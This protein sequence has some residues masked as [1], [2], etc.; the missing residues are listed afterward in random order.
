MKYLYLDNFRGFKKT[1]IPIKDINFLVGENSTG[2]TSILGLIKKISQKNFL[3]ELSF[4]LDELNIRLFDDVINKK[5]PDSYYFSI[6]M[7]QLDIDYKVTKAFLKTFREIQDGIS[8]LY[9]YTYFH[10]NNEITFLYDKKTLGKTKEHERSYKIDEFKENVYKNWQIEHINKNIDHSNYKSLTQDNENAPIF[11]QLNIS[12]VVWIAPIRTKPKRT[13]DEF[14]Y[15][16]SP[17][18]EHTPYIMKKI[19]DDKD[20]AKNFKNIL[21]KFGKQSGMFDSIKVKKF[22]NAVNSPFELQVGLNNMSINITN[23]GYG[24]SQSLPILVE[25]IARPKDTTFVMQQP[26]LHFHPKA[27]AALGDLIY[28]LFITE[29]KKFFIETH[30]DYIIDRFRLNLKNKD[31]NNP[32]AQ[33][34]FFERDKDGNKVYPID[35]LENGELSEDQPTAYQDFFIQEEIKN[36]GI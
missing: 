4:N 2:K 20:K 8:G 13:Y 31:S 17:E 5:L 1:Y 14:K 34:L 36:L 27:Q 21:N 35:I 24:V 7:I 10:R 9:M 22:G 6:G 11:H 26:E 16:Y 29:G 19:F 32:K 33:I 30:S 23:V 25:F 28:K 3:S 18:G 12:N 15:E